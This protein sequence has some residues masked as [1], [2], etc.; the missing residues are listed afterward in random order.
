MRRQ[1]QQAAGP[2]PMQTTASQHARR[3]SRVSTRRRQS[4]LAQASSPKH[5]R[6]GGAVEQADSPVFCQAPV[7]HI[8]SVTSLPAG[9]P[10]VASHARGLTP[11]V[12]SVLRKPVFIPG[13][14]SSMFGLSPKILRVAC[15]GDAP[16]LI[17]IRMRANHLSWGTTPPRLYRCC[18]LRPV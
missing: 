4:A 7:N 11:I 13:R 15:V 18:A 14:P 8:G 17:R 1:R 9:D 12:M 5:R 16:R 3:K 2:A 6:D 10:R